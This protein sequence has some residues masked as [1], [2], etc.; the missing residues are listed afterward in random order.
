MLYGSTWC[1]VETYEKSEAKATGI[2]STMSPAAVD[3]AVAHA[4]EEGGWVASNTS[5]SRAWRGRR[6]GVV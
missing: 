5:M 4:I 1:V 3:F 2:H 6:T